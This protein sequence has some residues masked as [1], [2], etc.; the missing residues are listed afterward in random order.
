[1][2]W[3]PVLLKATENYLE[4]SK[5]YMLWVGG[6]EVAGTGEPYVAAPSSHSQDEAKVVCIA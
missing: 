3:K 2:Y 4:M 5:P 1:L 6:K